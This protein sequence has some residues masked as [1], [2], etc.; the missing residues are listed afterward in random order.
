[1]ARLDDLVLSESAH[2]GLAFR[3]HVYAPQDHVQ[4]LQDLLALAN[5]DVGGP[6]FLCFGVRDVPGSPR[7]LTGISAASVSELKGSLPR[8]LADSIEPQLKM[9][10]RAL[11]VHD[12]LVALLCLTECDDPPYLLARSVAGS[13]AGTGWVRRGTRHLPLLRGD[14]QRMFAAKSAVASEP[15]AVRVGFAGER[16]ETEISLPVLPLEGLPSAKAARQL[17]KMLDAKESAKEILGRTETQFARLMYAQQFGMDG[18][19]EPHSEESLRLLIG[20]APHD[21]RAADEH[22]EFEVRTHKL[23]IVVSNLGA[24]ALHGVF[25]ELTIPRLPG[26]GVTEHLVAAPGAQLHD[27][28]YPLVNVRG[29][30][31]GVQA[32]VGSLAAGESSPAFKQP[33]RFWVR[34]AAAGKTLAVDCTVHA[35]ELREPVTDTLLIAISAL[36]AAPAAKRRTG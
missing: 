36:A 33:P 16:I 32:E 5:A 20:K 12:E 24:S 30:T 6:R 3:E 25:V 9:T 31:I 27:E 11:K 1:M 29:H 23:N 18:A 34:E 14:L 22:Y 28:A 2:S 4:L 35:R 21:Y 17:R 26:I 10:L 8:L 13:P 19:Y 15:N 7:V